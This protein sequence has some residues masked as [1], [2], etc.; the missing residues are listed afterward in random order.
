[1]CFDELS[2]P[3]LEEYPV[4]YIRDFLEFILKNYKD[5]YWH[6]LPKEMAEYFK[7]AYINKVHEI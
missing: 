3:T 4:R 2:R 5:Q 1:M 7:N 6:V